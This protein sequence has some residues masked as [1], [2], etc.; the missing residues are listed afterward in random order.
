MPRS[1]SRKWGGFL[2]TGLTMDDICINR[3]Q[4]NEQS[5][6]ANQRA[7]KELDRQTVLNFIVKHGRGY[8]KQIARYMGKPLNCI[9]GRISELKA[10]EVIEDTG[11]RAEGCAIYQLRNNQLRLI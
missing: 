10:D 6:T 1:S 4:G 2:L 11:D 5:I 7:N 3:H 8:S 9:S